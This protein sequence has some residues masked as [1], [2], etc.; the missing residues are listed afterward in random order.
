LD[1]G[2]RSYV[3]AAAVAMPNAD[4]LEMVPPPGVVH[5]RLGEVLREAALL[6]RLLR[7]AS[8]A[9]AERRRR[10]EADTNQ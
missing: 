4:R 7:V 2:L 9:E 3:M 5:Q 6:R 1:S 10:A 8:E